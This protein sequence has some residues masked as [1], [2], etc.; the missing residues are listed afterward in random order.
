MYLDFGKK[1][2][3]SLFLPT[4]LTSLGS[5]DRTT[6]TVNV[7]VASAMSGSRIEY[8]LSSNWRVGAIREQ[9]LRK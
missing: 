9:Y 4:L 8:S 7:L 5:P 2:K 6:L 1:K 3:N